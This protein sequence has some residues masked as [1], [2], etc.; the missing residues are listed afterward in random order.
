MKEYHVVSPAYGRDYKSGEAAFADW[1]AG[2]DFILR[3]IVSAWRDK[4]C[5]IRDFHL[6]DQIEIRYNKLTQLLVH[7]IG[8]DPIFDDD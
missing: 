5:S 7:T 1:K 8:R 6:D 2:K 3:D 4:P